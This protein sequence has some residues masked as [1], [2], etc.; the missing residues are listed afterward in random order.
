[1]EFDFN[2]YRAVRRPRG[3]T[4]ARHDRAGWT[5]KNLILDEALD[6]PRWC[7]SHGGENFANIWR[8]TDNYATENN[9]NGFETRIK[10]LLFPFG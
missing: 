6:W 9:N 10:H 4:T 8:C 5:G 2:R 7:G 3:V 1:M